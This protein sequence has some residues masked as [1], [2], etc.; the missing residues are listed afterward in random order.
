MN[1]FVLCTGRCGS[2][3]FAKACS[4]FTNY[5]A[6]HESRSDHLR[7]GRVAFPKNHIEVDLRLAFYTGLL[8]RF[9]GRQAF[10]VHLIRDRHA[11]AASYLRKWQDKRRR[12]AGLVAAWRGLMRNP[13]DRDVPLMIEDMIAVINGNIW[14][15]LRDKPHLAMD[16]EDAP[17]LFPLFARHIGAEGDMEAALAEFAIRHNAYK[18]KLKCA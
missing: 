5:T 1:V 12:V 7:F 15:F 4:H 10:Y 11:V 6:G 3:T 16:I 13:A 8:E 18:E 14:Q 2:M 17:R 9:H